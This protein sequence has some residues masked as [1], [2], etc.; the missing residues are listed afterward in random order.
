MV[1]CSLVHPPAV[2]G[3]IAVTKDDVT[4][5]TRVSGSK[6]WAYNGR[7]LYCFLVDILLDIVNGE[8]LGFYN[9]ELRL[10]PL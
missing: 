3:Q 7:S 4:I 10:K 8:N 1:C 9:V 6:R 2:V 5:I